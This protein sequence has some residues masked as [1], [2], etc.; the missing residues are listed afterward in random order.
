MQLSKIS[1]PFRISQPGYLFLLALLM[2]DLSFGIYQGKSIVQKIV[3]IIIACYLVFLI[4][5]KYPTLKI[6]TALAFVIGLISIKIFSTHKDLQLTA[7]TIVKVYPDQIKIKD[8]WLSGIGNSNGQKV[9][10]SGKVNE[11][12]ENI[13]KRGYPI[14][15]TRLSGEINEIEGAT[16]FGQ[17]DY[18]AYYAAKNIFQKIRFK[19]CTIETTSVSY[20]DKMHYFRFELQQYFKKMPKLLGFFASELILAENNSSDNHD[21]LD[22]YR[23]LGVIHL[24]S[25]SGLHVGIYTLVI[26]S[27]CYFFK[28]TQERAFIYTIIILCLEIFLSGGQAGFIRASLT[29]ILGKVFKFKNWKISGIDLLGLTCLVHLLFIPRLFLG[30]GAI[31]SYIL[32]LGLQLTNNLSNFKQSILL[33][34]FLTP[35]LLFYF[36]QVNILTVLFNMLI[37]PYFNYIVLPITF[38]NIATFGLTNKFAVN[39][40][41][42]LETCEKVIGQ[43]SETQA[44]MLLFGKINWWECLLLLLISAG[45]LVCIN[46]KSE[47][48]KLNIRISSII[49][50]IYASIFCLIHFPLRGQVTFIDVGQGDSILITTPLNRHVYMVDTGGKLNFSGEKVNPQINRITIPLLKAQGISR[51][52]GLFVTHQDADHVGDLGP[53]LEKVQVDKLYMAKGLIDNPSFQK[54]IYSKVSHTKL[55][56]LLAGMQVKE[57]INFNVVYPFKSGEG[58]NEDS[59]SLTFK[60][61]NKRWL[62]TG[63]LG[64]EG[65]KEIINKFDIKADY[66][67]L[68]HHGSKTSSNPEFLA[69]LK[70][71]LVFISAGRKNRFG[72]P[73][74]E[75]LNTL[76]SLHIPWVSTQ[77]YG[78]ISWYYGWRQPKFKT[79]L[80]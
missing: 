56:E 39:L 70:P 42:I 41:N 78:M 10:I 9:S 21:V 68:G 33:N 37:V 46:E 22:N 43:I 74:P 15:L 76:K 16:N 57:A 34:L 55:V 75:T 30:I 28:I 44:G 5:K 65:E 51:I 12:Q 62:F 66:F 23:D 7:N 40:E 19:S 53:L 8:N 79:F 38:F 59:L 36:Y 24:L 32:V 54:R 3:I 58:K 48:K 61:A 31:L 4:L 63:D 2:T 52:D 72:H 27:L 67:K 35:L 14:Y 77:D 69:K 6:I 73:H 13:I 80:E 11:S 64:Q 47:N 18:Q 60:V 1:L 29:Y 49:F 50:T 45:L 71:E 20:W 26:A 17:F 25:I